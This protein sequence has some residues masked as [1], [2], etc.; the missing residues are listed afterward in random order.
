MNDLNDMAGLDSE[1]A[2]PEREAATKRSTWV[3]VIVNIFLTVTRCWLGSC[4]TL[5]A[6]SPMAFTR[7]PTW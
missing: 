2:T 4:P 6:L 7:Y 3:S 1:D 5:K